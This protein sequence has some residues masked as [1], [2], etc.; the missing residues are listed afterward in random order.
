VLHAVELPPTGAHVL[1]TASP[2]SITL[3]PKPPT[4]SARNAWEATVQAVGVLGDRVRVT[5]VATNP[6][7]GPHET[8]AEVTRDAAREL[9]ISQGSTVFAAIKATDLSISPY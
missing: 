8:V 6:D 3:F 1:A 4:G 2:T 9:A 5:F 7:A